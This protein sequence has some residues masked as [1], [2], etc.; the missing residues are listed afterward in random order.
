MPV[1]AGYVVR[2]SHLEILTVCTLEV[3]H[4]PLS[5]CAKLLNM[6]DL[7]GLFSDGAVRHVSFFSS[8]VPEWQV[9]HLHEVDCS[10]L[11][12]LDRRDLG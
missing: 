7:P 12:N 11:V 5:R 1:L 10:S 9:S 4:L 3:P 6:S 2:K 8:C